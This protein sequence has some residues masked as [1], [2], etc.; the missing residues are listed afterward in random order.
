MLND[1]EKLS[2]IHKKANNALYFNDNSDYPTTLWEILEVINPDI[3]ANNP[4]PKL[5]YLDE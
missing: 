3:F 2:L 4:E 5:E 1:K